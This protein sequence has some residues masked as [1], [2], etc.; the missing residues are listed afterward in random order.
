MVH[1]ILSLPV[2]AVGW[3]IAALFIA[4]SAMGQCSVGDACGIFL[5]S[6]PLFLFALD[7]PVSSFSRTIR[8]S[9]IPTVWITFVTYNETF[10]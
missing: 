5:S 8:E 4:L 1:I 7:L 2:L 10:K 6:I 9:N 3:A